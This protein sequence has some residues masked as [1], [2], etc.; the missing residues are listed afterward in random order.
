MV[1]PLLW[2]T[3]AGPVLVAV[4]PFKK[5]HLH[6]NDFLGGYRDKTLHAPHVYTVADAAFSEMMRGEYNIVVL[7]SI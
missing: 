7:D 1:L 4:N 3:K 2:Q 6:G 5:V